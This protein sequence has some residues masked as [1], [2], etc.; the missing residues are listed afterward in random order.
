MEPLTD[1][2]TVAAVSITGARDMVS[3]VAPGVWDVAPGAA[4]V[5]S[6]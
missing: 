5:P 6:G 2:A 4:V 1:V 3:D